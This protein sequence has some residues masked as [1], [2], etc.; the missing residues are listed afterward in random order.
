ML[1][2]VFVLIWLLKAIGIVI[3]LHF[4]GGRGEEFTSRVS[5][6]PG[7]SPDLLTVL[8]DFIDDFQNSG[9]RNGLVEASQDGSH[10]LG[11]QVALVLNVKGL[12]GLFQ[13]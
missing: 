7:D 10:R 4:W 13:L 2:N 3:H 8:I 12:E 1:D 6:A 11:R 9:L 5:G